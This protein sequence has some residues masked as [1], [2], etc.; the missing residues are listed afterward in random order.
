MLN[1]FPAQKKKQNMSKDLFAEIAGNSIEESRQLYTHQ[2]EI[3]PGIA[4][5]DERHQPESPPCG[6][7]S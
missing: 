5:P 2:L 6:P 7:F 1:H 3:L 4:L